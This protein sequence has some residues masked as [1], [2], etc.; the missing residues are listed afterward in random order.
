MPLLRASPLLRSPGARPLALLGARPLSSLPANLTLAEPAP[1]ATPPPPPPRINYALR[2][3][4]IH[5]DVEAF[6]DGGAASPAIALP[7]DVFAAPL[8]VDVLHDCVRWQRNKR[9]QV[10]RASKRRGEVSGSTRKLYRQKG[11]GNARAGSLR[12]PLRK[13]GAKAHGPAARDFKTELN[14]KQRRLALRVALSAKLREGRLTVAASLDTPPK[15][16]V[17][18]DA[19]RGRGIRS[20][21]FVDDDLAEDFKTACRNVPLVDV[22]PQVGA[23]VYSILQRDHLVLSESAAC[24]RPASTKRKGRACGVRAHPP[25]GARSPPASRRRTPGAFKLASQTARLLKGAARRTATA[26]PHTM[27]TMLCCAGESDEPDGSLSLALNDGTTM[28]QIAFGLYLIPK[29]E[30][31]A[32]VQ[33]AVDAGYRHFDGAAFYDNEAAAATAL[34]PD[35]FYTSK[36]WT[37]DKTFDDAVASVRRSA[38]ELGRPLDLAPVG[39]PHPRRPSRAF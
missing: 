34:T 33:A 14:K 35:C 16:R 4:E 20:A 10:H 1:T 38:K 9:R 31:G 17:V 19:L 25:A 13:G 5:V 22:L 15:T 23:N 18:A 30:A 37:T 32:C 11:T 26:R 29:D 7:A 36:V 8:R 21:L 2:G 24:G 3:D 28:P 39:V 6:F 12:S 27:N